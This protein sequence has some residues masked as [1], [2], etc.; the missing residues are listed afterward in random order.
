VD[1]R[2]GHILE[3]LGA[4]KGTDYRG[5]QTFQP[6]KRARVRGRRAPSA[7]GPGQSEDRIF[8]TPAGSGGDD[9]N[10]ALGPCLRSSIFSILEYA[11]LGAVIWRELRSLAFLLPNTRRFG[12]RGFG[13]RFATSVFSIPRFAVFSV[14]SVRFGPF[15]GADLTVRPRTAVPTCTGL[16]WEASPGAHGIVC[17]G[18]HEGASWRPFW[19]CSRRPSGRP[20]L[21]FFPP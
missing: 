8:G 14:S 1:A 11:F 5:T 13:P 20:E 10:K 15:L 19:G 17:E 3:D 2:R 18:V 4:K 9:G 6:K 16:F 21:G 12:P 7:I